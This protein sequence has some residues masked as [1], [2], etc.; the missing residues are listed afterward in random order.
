MVD[1]NSLFR[2]RN[3]ISTFFT[4]RR[5]NPNCAGG[6]GESARINGTRPDVLLWLPASLVKVASR[7]KTLFASGAVL[8][9]KMMMLPSKWRRAVLTQNPDW[10]PIGHGVGPWVVI[11]EC[12][13]P[14]S[15][16]L[17]PSEKSARALLRR[18]KQH[19]CGHGCKLGRLNKQPHCLGKVI[20]D[21]SL[22]IWD[23]L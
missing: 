8:K 12:S 17:R 4:K 5:I 15:F 3:A 1:G 20:K 23:R 21:N 2:P 14:F 18:W 10:K 6:I 16:A 7:V 11:N 19:G 13:R 9:G 22:M